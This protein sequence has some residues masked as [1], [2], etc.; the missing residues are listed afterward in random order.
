LT[1]ET[2]DG[3]REQRFIVR[4]G[5]S[6]QL[7]GLQA[8]PKI[9]VDGHRVYYVQDD[10]G[11]RQI[12][13]RLRDEPAPRIKPDHYELRYPLEPGTQWWRW[14]QTQALEKTGPPQRT[15]YRIVVPVK[16]S[17]TVESIDESVTVAAGRFDRCVLVSGSGSTN[18][19]VRNYVGKAR[20]EVETYDW[21]APDVGL[22]KSVRRERTSSPA[23]DYGAYVM[24]LQELSR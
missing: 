17:V 8:V 14:T 5:A 4:N 21:Y 24:E 10:T 2:E 22:I 23:L 3:R 7:A 13:A 9:T 15:H 6:E 19:D 20:I 11:I 1:L 12:A 16:L 18:A